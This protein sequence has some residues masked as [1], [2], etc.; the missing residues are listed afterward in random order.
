[1]SIMNK[2]NKFNEECAL[3]GIW[4]H[5]E[6][7]NMAYLSLYA[8]QHRGQEGAGVV[9]LELGK[10]AKFHVHKGMGLVSDV[11]DD[12][13]FSRLMGTCSIGH[14]L[15]AMA[16]SQKL[17]NVQPL[18]AEISRGAVAIAHNGN[19][20]NAE[21]LREK[22]IDDGAIFATSSDTEIVLHLLARTSKNILQVEGVISAVSQLRGAYSLLLM[23]QDRLFAVRDPNG[24]RP[25]ALG[26][27]DGSYVVVSETCAL[28]LI[29]AQYIR[30]IEPGEV[31]EI[32]KDSEI[33]SYFPFGMVKE[34]PCIFEYVYFARPDSKVFG[35][36]V[37]T[38][39]KNMGRELCKE[40]PAKADIVIPVPDSGVPAALGF[41]QEAG[42]PFEYGL[43]R[44][45]YVGRTFIE[46]KQSIRDFGVKVKL[47]PNK[48]VL[49]G[50]SVVVVDD[51]IVRGTTCKKL[52]K[53]IR[54][55]G[56]KEVHMR[57][58]SPPTTDPCYYGVDTPAKEKLIASQKNVSEIAEYIGADS[59]A[60]LSLEGL[61]KAVGT[62]V[63][64]FCDACFSGCYPVA[65]SGIN[66]KAVQ[67][68]LFEDLS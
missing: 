52:I 51:S 28:D 59:L 63:G 15:Y 22:L 53:L 5:K 7:A 2:I 57:I 4:N 24:F 39:R 43:M 40:A 60:Y 47:N 36:D 42:I 56:A 26:M 41:A 31:L 13:D 33:K 58:S 62:P 44:N 64:K 11:F 54:L 38:I 20:V 46:P 21:E 55:A 14:V 68:E 50:K 17:V 6:A 27:V 49:D 65:I 8:Q 34:S 67:Q 18:Y 12:F 66:G 23:F 10:D 61:Y 32:S 25:L 19:I 16:K 45:H 35:R 30:E 48:G 29:G 37:Y 1:M 9:S 3:V